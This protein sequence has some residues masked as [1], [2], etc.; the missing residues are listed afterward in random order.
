MNDALEIL[1]S[2][3]YNWNIKTRL[4]SSL[5][6]SL[7]FSK[8]I[9]FEFLLYKEFNNAYNHISCYVKQVVFLLIYWCTLKDT[10]QKCN[11]EKKVKPIVCHVYYMNSSFIAS[12]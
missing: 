6:L 12:R 5:R 3:R 10:D 8:K 11:G 7:P 4:V 1:S 2:L 9:K